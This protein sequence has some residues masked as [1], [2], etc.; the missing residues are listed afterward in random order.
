VEADL[1]QEVQSHLEMLAEENIRAGMPPQEAQR[2]ARI[3]LGGIEQVKEQVREERIGNWLRSVI[4][5]CRYGL[6][7]GGQVPGSNKLG[8]RPKGASW[9]IITRSHSHFTRT[10]RPQPCY[11]PF[12]SNF[13]PTQ[14]RDK[15]RAPL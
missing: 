1:D 5:D 8:Q 6:R 14:E 13:G 15:W 9:E 4:S 7:Q 12:Q 10:E 3:Q 2:D 11:Q